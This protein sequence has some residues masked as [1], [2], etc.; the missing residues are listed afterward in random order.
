MTMTV[1]EFAQELKVPAKILITQLRAAGVD[2]SNE[3][4]TLSDADK[5]RLLD[6]LRIERTQSSQR[7]ITLTR[8][9]KSVIKQSDASGRA[10][11]IQVEVRR[12]RVFVKNPQMQAEE[13]ARMEAE[14][15]AIAERRAAEE[16]ARE[17]AEAARRKA[18]E[19]RRAA[20][21][22]ARREREEAE[23]AAAAARAAEAAKAAEEARAREE[24]AKKS[25]D[26]AALKAARREAEKAKLEA[27][28][29]QATSARMEAEA[30]ANARREAARKKAEEEARRIREMMN[31]KAGV[32]TAKKPPKE[33]KPK[34]EE[35]PAQPQKAA[36]RDDKKP[37]QQTR[38]NNAT[39]PAA[40][41]STSGDKRPHGEKKGARRQSDWQENDRKGRGLK[42]RGAVDDETSSSGWRTA[43]GRRSQDRHRQDAPVPQSQEPVVREVTVPETI[44]VADLAHK[45]AVKATEVI[46]TLMTMGQMCTINQMLDQDTAML[47]VEEMGH[48]AI[49]AKADDP[50]AWLGEIE[51]KEDYPEKPRPPVVTI[52]GHVD[53]GKTSLLDYIR[54]AK[55]AA[56]E[57]GGITQHIGA[58]HVKTPRGIITFLDTPGH[59]AFTAMRARG[60][61]ATDIVILVVAADDG[62]MP[63]TQE[64]ISHSRAAGVPLVVA[65]NK[66]DKPEANPERVKQELVTAGVIP[67]EYG[68]D[69]PFCPVSAKT[70]Q[71][72]DELLENVLLQA[73]MLDLKA[74][75]EGPAKGLVI[76]SR[77]DKGRGPVASILVQSG[78]LHR[79]DVVLVGAEF[80]RVR[81]MINELGK[82]QNTAGPSIPV[83]IQGLSG[84]PQAGDEVIS[85]ADER[86]ARE[87]ALFRQGKY[88]DV[89]LAKAHATNLANL[90]ADVGE[91]E[92]KTLPLIIK[93]DVQGS[94]EALIHALTQLSNNEVRVSVVHAAVGGISESDVNLAAASKAVIIGFNVRAD[95]QARKLAETEGVDIR[96][97]NIIYDAV[98]DV[99]AALSGMLSPER[100]ETPLGLVEI[101]Q[102]IRVPK[103]GNIAGCRVLEGLV[104]RTAQVR[105]LRDNVV[106]W[107]GELA[108]LKH[109][110]DDVREVKAG[111]ECGLSLKGY[112]DIKTGDQLEVFEVTEVARSL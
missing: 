26:E 49:A 88:R 5:S 56:G 97:Y 58:Y 96:Y 103:V 99:K 32:L 81:A 34:A 105:L 79:G 86:K 68:G 48:K 87:I 1:K 13:E 78:T 100:R 74:P 40:A 72:V 3:T 28:V 20:E 82:A 46:K 106:V 65:I 67:E 77:L 43:R 63:Q 75:D 55:V 7:K 101:R 107:T 35:K 33:E 59:E 16:K 76:E 53:H 12:K 64:A 50:E 71:G 47:V 4:D 62:V 10:H 95:A 37:A 69:V 17:E 66:I 44:S 27:E 94:Q 108:S 92:V 93:A 18:E 89:K 70:G 57:A 110:K 102:I 109:F 45:M 8:K 52:M 41:P 42:T 36:G 19:E 91:G 104:R 22:K 90:F 111:N 31:R 29:A 80:G 98:D 30:A 23:R 38:R 25:A 60:A 84:V 9:E 2:K 54:R 83:E 15:R 14:A 21:E 51:E 112:E 24:A 73:E 61:Q 6:S 11:T 39:R 85:L